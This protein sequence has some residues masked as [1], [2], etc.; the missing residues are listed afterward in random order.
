MKIKQQWYARGITIGH[1]KVF[2]DLDFSRQI[3]E[4]WTEISVIPLSASIDSAAFHCWQSGM[5]HSRYV[6]ASAN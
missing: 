6:I 4:G 1:Q 5:C 2:V 3:L